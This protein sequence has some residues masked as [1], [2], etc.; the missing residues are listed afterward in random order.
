MQRVFTGNND[1][2]LVRIKE[3]I[4]KCNKII[5][6]VSFIMDSG[7][8]LIIESLKKA[9]EKDCKIE[10]FTT[11]YMSVTEPIALYRLLTQ[12]NDKADIFIYNPDQLNSFHPKAYFFEME[13]DISELI[14]GS[15][16]LSKSALVTGVEWNILLEKDSDPQE[17]AE[18]MIAYHN[19]KSCYSKKLDIEW[20]RDYQN[21]YVN[22]GFYKDNNDQK[23][24]NTAQA[25]EPS[26]AYSQ[27][28]PFGF[29][30]PA[31]YELN[32]TREEGYNK[33]LVIAAT[34]LG[35]TYMSAFDSKPFNKILFI[36]H[37]EEILSQAAK[38]F[39]IVSPHKKTGILT[40][41]EKTFFSNTDIVFA[42]VQTI[43]KKDFLEAGFFTED[44]FD[45]III[46]EFHH[47]AAYSYQNIL[48][49]FKPKF[50]LGMTA[51]PDRMDNKDIYKLCDYN[52][53]CEFNLK[54]SINQ[55][56]LSPFRYYGIYDDIDYSKVSIKNGNYN[57]DEL[58]ELLTIENRAEII[59]SKYLD[60][61]IKKTVAFCA[62]IKHADYMKSYFLKH[63]VKCASLHSQSEN[64]DYI[65]DDLSNGSISVLFVVDIFNEGIDLPEIDSVMF[66]RPT[67][68]YTIFMQQLGRGLRKSDNKEFLTI[69]DFVGNYKGAHLKPY[70][71][72]GERN[73][74]KKNDAF[75][76]PQELEIPYG[77]YVNF[78]LRIID[79]YK[80]MS[81]NRKPVIFLLKEDYAKIRSYKGSELNV[82]DIFE[83]SEYS[84]SFYRQQFNS[85][86]NLKRE[87]QDL[88]KY[89]ESITGSIIDDFFE[90]L[91]ITPM[92][93]SYKMCVLQ[94]FLKTDNIVHKHSISDI[95]VYFKNFYNSNPVHQKDVDNSL[96]KSDLKNWKTL[97]LRNPLNFLAS[98]DM[99]MYFLLDKQKDT[100]SFSD[101]LIK[102]VDSKGSEFKSYLND[103]VNYR[104]INYFRR[105]YNDPYYR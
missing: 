21:R 50:L 42:S 68:S 104:M 58:E 91:I 54:I 31:L 61:N 32:K 97:L 59:L 69:L 15:S 27:V 73:S 55:N 44:Y 67:E 93:R 16:N 101:Q 22:K 89:E 30:I 26:S 53:A 76:N 18:F 4:E 41:K 19:L 7:I 66:L 23:S 34:G 102:S 29:Q 6:V 39:K 46:D 79:L 94:Y 78:D 25:A 75:L 95:A 48:S 57:T 36:A 105:K 56:W 71:L 77:C 38:S 28:E 72:S 14:I 60:F 5:F 43:G 80:E 98:G 47:A 90:K 35:K 84:V 3:N 100:F 10:I 81:S 63:K 11:D 70:Y 99:K 103:I 83:E 96:L 51:T 1:E 8:K 87:M 12:L 74:L 92:T 33:A 40:G 85:W 37:R 13:N 65:I 62:G 9:I 86:F 45:Y 24:D 64:R 82:M 88:D 49:F 52:I 17:Y 2:L 20:L